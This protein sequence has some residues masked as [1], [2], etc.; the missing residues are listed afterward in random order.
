[1]KLCEAQFEF[2]DEIQKMQ[3]SDASLVQ[4][5]KARLYEHFA[6]RKKGDATIHWNE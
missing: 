5:N 3:S 1:M 6:W 2:H 4:S